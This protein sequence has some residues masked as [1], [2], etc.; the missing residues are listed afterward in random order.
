MSLTVFVRKSLM[1]MHKNKR[2]EKKHTA[3]FIEDDR[4]HK[5]P[6]C[7]KRFMQSSHLK[8]HGI[9]HVK[10]KPFNCDIC[11]KGYLRNG[12]LRIHI[13]KHENKKSFV[14][15]TCSKTFVSISLLKK[16][17]KTHSGKRRYGCNTCGKRFIFRTA[18][19]MH[20]IRH[21]EEMPFECDI[22][23]KKFK[24]H[25]TMKF[26]ILD[27]M[28]IGKPYKC[29]FCTKSFS[30]SSYLSAHTQKHKGVKPNCE[31]ECDICKK[32]YLTKNSLKS[33]MLIH[34]DKKSFV[35]DICS[36]S[37]AKKTY[38]NVHKKLHLVKK[39]HQCSICTKGF[40]TLYHLQIHLQSH[41]GVK[42]FECEVCQKRFLRKHGLKSHMRIHKKVQNTK[43]T[44]GDTCIN[45]RH[46]GIK[47]FEC[48]ICKQKFKKRETM[49]VH[50]M[51]HMS[52]C[53]GYMCPVCRKCFTRS[54]NLNKH[55]LIHEK[56]K[57]DHPKTLVC[58][59]CSKIFAKVS[60]LNKHK[61]ICG[62]PHDCEICGKRII[63]AKKFN[64]HL[65]IHTEKPFKCDVCEQT[66]RYKHYLKFHKMIHMNGKAKK[67]S[68]QQPIFHTV[69]CKSYEETSD[70]NLDYKDNLE[71]ITES[72]NFILQPVKAEVDNSLD[73]N[74]DCGIEFEV[75]EEKYQ[76]TLADNFE[77]DCQA[78]NPNNFYLDE[79]NVV[80][81]VK[82]EI[83]SY[84]E[85]KEKSNFEIQKKTR[86]E[87]TM[88]ENQNCIILFPVKR[89]EIKPDV[90]VME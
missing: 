52:N 47:D 3:T 14:C 74:S 82:T 53:K 24:R 34:E 49:K 1:K 62:I 73:S 66:F 86:F 69:L 65:R 88:T 48:D 26:H 68:V 40:V 21:T 85:D 29:A 22:C 12:D 43:R 8:L 59:V 30:R 78:N 19:N 13:L 17:Q 33:H 25:I 87:S 5:C 83:M 70:D 16:H 50:I 28:G 67:T 9:S 72:E 31:F 2:V 89:E 46:S 15:D 63:G 57:K 32:R 4:P 64:L 51:A 45:K 41:S 76:T 23:K 44:S 11:K 36:K 60:S 55:R 6:I 61:K 35:C 7:P 37:F 75:K 27:H 84:E 77:S 90:E 20:M 80:S 39:P 10:V 58:D 79:D 54:Y 18:L 71:T 42:P 56:K 81:T 38:V